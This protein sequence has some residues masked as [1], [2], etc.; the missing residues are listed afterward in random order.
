MTRGFQRTLARSPIT[1]VLLGLLAAAPAAVRADTGLLDGRA[2][3]VEMQ[4]KGSEDVIPNTLTFRS[5]T[6]LSAVCVQHDFPQS[7]YEAT[8]TGDAVTFEVAAQS[9]TKGHMDWEGTVRGDRLEATAV[10]YRPDQEPVE[11]RIRGAAK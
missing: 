11:F 3:E 9:Y 2:F 8:R 4:K 6:F 1:L 10:W 7:T 5:G